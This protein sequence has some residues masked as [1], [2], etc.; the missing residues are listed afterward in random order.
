MF[1]A[2]HARWL[3]PGLWHRHAHQLRSKAAIFKSPSGLL[4]R[5]QCESILVGARD[6]TP[7]G[8]IFRRLPECIGVA[9][10]LH[11]RVREAPAQRGVRHLRHTTWI[12]RVR[13]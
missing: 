12:R 11:L 1:I 10:L 6:T 7:L 2:L 8:D 4:L 9:P 3:A 5:Q 13:L